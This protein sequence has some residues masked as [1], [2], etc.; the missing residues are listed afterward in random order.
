LP[1]SVRVVFIF[2]HIKWGSGQT[3]LSRLREIAGLGL[4]EALVDHCVGHFEEPCDI[5]A[6]Y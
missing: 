2:T 3:L 1:V 4:D 6:V 5:G